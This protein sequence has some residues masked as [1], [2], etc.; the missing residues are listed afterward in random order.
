MSEPAEAKMDKGETTTETEELTEKT[1]EPTGISYVIYQGMGA[2]AVGVGALAC[3]VTLGYTSPALPSMRAD[4]DFFITEEQESWV[5][6]VMPACA[7]V[8]SVIT[9]PLVDSLGRRTTLLHLT[10]PFALSWMMIAT[11]S[12]VTGVVLGRMMG[13][14]CVGM[15]AVAGSVF[16]PEIVEVELRNIMTA[17]PAVFG[18][19]GLMLSFASG[20]YLT[21]RGL[22]WLGALM[23]LPVVLFLLPLPETP[24]HLTRTGRKES[25]LIALRQLRR[26]TQ[27]AEKE[28]Q[29]ITNSCSSSDSKA[30]ISVWETVQSPNLWPVSVG[31]GL[32]VAQQTT[33]ITAVVFFASSILD[34]GEDGAGGSAASVLL[35]VV[36]FF[37]TFVGM[38]AMAKF[39]RRQMLSLSTTVI[40]ASLFIL[41]LFFWA[42]DAGGSYSDIA[43]TLHLVPVVGLLAYII[44]FSLGWG[45]I[46]WVFLGE[47]MPSRVRGKAVAMVVAVNWASA[48]LITKTFGWCVSSLGAHT[49][50]LGY[51]VATAVSATLLRRVMP[52]TFL[53]SAAQMN[54]LY[55]EAAKIK[56]Q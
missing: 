21:W 11:S 5:G 20:Q 51:A 44:G 38:I 43:K 49:T 52:E 37:S 55:Q 2:A 13:G 25:S 1:T 3:S 32:M 27:H 6:A 47:G 19:L 29:E 17:I 4:P 22:A 56:Q 41:S 26:T 31:I 42:K 40:V 45:P 54:R 15:Q 53:Q 33:G 14:L 16:L 28:Q 7:L 34:S 12:S 10:W 8:G 24:S 36:N 30:D 18:N 23:T 46:P 50:F 39:K 48:F 35:G 9:G